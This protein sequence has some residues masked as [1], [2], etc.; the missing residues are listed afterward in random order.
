MGV[1]KSL[2]AWHNIQP[3]F[4]RITM[5]ILSQ[6]FWIRKWRLKPPSSQK[7][8]YTNL[9]MI[10]TLYRLQQSPVAFVWWHLLMLIYHLCA[11]IHSTPL[12]WLCC[13]M[14][15]HSSVHLKP[16][17]IAEKKKKEKKNS[18]HHKALRKPL[19]SD[20]PTG[21]LTVVFPQPLGPIKSAELLSPISTVLRKSSK[22]W[23]LSFLW[24]RNTFSGNNNPLLMTFLHKTTPSSRRRVFSII[25][26]YTNIHTVFKIG[27]RIERKMCCTTPCEIRVVNT[28]STIGGP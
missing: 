6:P 27:R 23:F 22:R 21:K 3:P 25:V 13:G 7:I 26:T 16:C 2:L 15:F 19:I 1:L 9:Q 8:R 28:N 11:L 12:L 10:Q 18:E 20:T 4:L 24:L 5:I 17:S 14:L